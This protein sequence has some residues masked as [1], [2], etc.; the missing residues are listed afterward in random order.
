MAIPRLYVETIRAGVTG[1]IV[2]LAIIFVPAWTLNYWRG[3]AYFATFTITSALLTIYMARYDKPLLESRLRAGPRAEQN[4]AQRAI[5][6][7]AM[8]VFVGSI[9][10]PVLDYRFGWSPL[11]PAWLSV[12]ADAVI[13]ASFLIIFFV[14]RENHF[15]AATVR[16]AENQTV[17]STGPYAVV[18]HPMYAGVL[19]MFIAT[20]LALGSWWG[21]LFFPAFV[22]VLV[23]RLLDEEKF[24]RVNLPGYPEYCTKVRWRLVPGIF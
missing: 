11:P 6:A 5:M 14:V 7:C 24:L 17:I 23:W 3:W 9:M 1:A 2:F 10:V 16:V 19:P 18:R 21:L 22:A 15:A 20:P 12:I 4:P 13:A 8:A